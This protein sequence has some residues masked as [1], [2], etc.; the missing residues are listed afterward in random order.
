MRLKVVTASEIPFGRLLPFALF[1][2]DANVLIASGQT[3]TPEQFALLEE[4]GVYRDADWVATVEENTATTIDIGLPA[5]HPI[6]GYGSSAADQQKNANRQ[7]PKQQEGVQYLRMNYAGS[8]EGFFVRLYGMVPGQSLILAAPTENGQLVFVKE[9]DNFDFKGFYS[10]AIYSF[11]AA[12]RQVCFQPFP[13]LHINWP[14]LSRVQKQI[15][16]QTRRID[17]NLPCTLYLTPD[18]KSTING[19][20]RNLSTG[21]AEVELFGH[22]DA[23]QTRVRIAFRVPVHGQKF[24]IEEETTIIGK[25]AYEDEPAER[26]GLSFDN[27]PYDMVLAL[28]GYIQ[29]TLLGRLETPLFAV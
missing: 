10:R 5:P 14:E 2:A 22:F 3:V 1:D 7:A 20:I 21:G 16:R 18:K 26:Y 9:G 8:E 29:E 13:Y 4:F 17:I 27:L 24:L 15:V 11:R 28:H 19:V 6:S 12:I 25:R 23:H